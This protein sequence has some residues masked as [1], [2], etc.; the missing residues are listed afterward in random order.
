MKL[1]KLIEL[2]QRQKEKYGQDIDVWSYDDFYCEPN[3]PCYNSYSKSI[4]F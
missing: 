4:E 2:L 3:E 1:G